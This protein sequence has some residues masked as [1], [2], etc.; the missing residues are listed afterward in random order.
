M[1]IKYLAPTQTVDLIYEGQGR[2]FV[3]SSVS[4]STGEAGG[5]DDL[6]GSI[7]KLS[8]SSGPQ[9]WIVDWDT[10]VYLEDKESNIEHNESKKVMH[11]HADTVV[12]LL[13]HDYMK[14][15]RRPPLVWSITKRRT[16]L[17]ADSTSKS[18][19]FAI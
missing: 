16:Q 15:Y 4:T 3:L 17:S 6:A 19:K 11:A 18:L 9:L 12:S 1:D 7:R 8:L 10:T 13:M 5:E 14:L 2:R